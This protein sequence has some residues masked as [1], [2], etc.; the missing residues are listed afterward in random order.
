MELS[1][2]ILS[3]FF[4][5]IS[6]LLTII[7]FKQNERFKDI[8][9]KAKYHEKIFDDY[10]IEYIPKCRTYIRFDYGYLTDFDKLTNCLAQ[11]ME[12]S[13]YFKYSNKTFYNRLKKLVT[14]LEDDLSKYS[15]TKT[16]NED[17]AKIYEDIHQRITSIYECIY[18]E[19]VGI[20]N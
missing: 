8:N 9:L 7:S 1:A 6:T 14:E 16:D 3:I 4:L 17:Q 5:I 10:L 15:N 12:K 2:L 18:N 11:M 13:I 19:Y 20:G